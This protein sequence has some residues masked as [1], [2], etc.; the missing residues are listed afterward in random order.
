MFIGSMF[1]T[2]S[3]NLH[4]WIL[5]QVMM[6][7]KSWEFTGVHFTRGILVTQLLLLVCLIRSNH[8]KHKTD[9][10][11]TILTKMKLSACTVSVLLTEISESNV[12]FLAWH[13]CL[14]YAVSIL[15]ALKLS[16]LNVEMKV[17]ELWISEAF[18]NIL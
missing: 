4:F 12:R 15:F 1:F 5:W 3:G 14:E 8:A 18:I 9:A 7:S 17:L 16:S 2:I 13:C 11:E 10:R 6:P